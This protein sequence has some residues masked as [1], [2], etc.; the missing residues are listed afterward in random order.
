MPI[1]KTINGKSPQIPNDCFVAEN[2]TIVGNVSMG[3]QCSIWFN[4]VIRGDVNFI[5]IGNKVNIQDGAVIHCT[6]QKYGTTIGNNVSIGHNALVHGCT[7][8]DNVLIGMGS[9]VMDGCIIE[10]NSI[11]AAGAVVTQNT[12]VKSGSIYAGVPAKKIKD[13]SK[14][15]ISGEINRIA[16]NYVTYSSWFK[17]H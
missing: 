12:T 2:A 17:E 15:L 4:A 14:T 7:I 9:I 8:K 6:Y 3:N 1:I 11:I 10:S 5:K 13:V 16:N